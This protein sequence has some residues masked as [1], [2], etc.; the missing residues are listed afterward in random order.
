MLDAGCGTGRLFSPLRAWGLHGVHGIDASEGMLAVSRRLHPGVRVRQA[1]LDRVPEPDASQA[2]ILSW[3]SIIHTPTELLGPVAAEFARLLRPGGLALVAFHS[4]GEPRPSR[5]LDGAGGNVELHPHPVPAVASALVEAG[6]ELV[7]SGLRP[8][9][10][11]ERD[12]Q[13][14]VL[15]RMLDRQPAAA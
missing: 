2:G 14:F 12:A 11:D 8:P 15:A 1:S 9:R 3:Y 10:A 6:L 4:G 13:A 5:F 7:A